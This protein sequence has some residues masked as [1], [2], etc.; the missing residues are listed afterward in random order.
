MIS[1]I[2][3]SIGRPSIINTL[4]SLLNQTNQDW[5]CLVGFDGIKEE[6]LKLNL[7]KDERIKYFYIDKKLGQIHNVHNHAGKVRNYLI[8]KVET[9]WIGFV[10]DDD[11]L[12][13]RYIEWFEKEKNNHNFDC[14][15]F[16]MKFSDKPLISPPYGC[17]SL[18]EGKVGISFVINK[19]F[20]NEN[21]IE[22][23]NY[24]SEDFIYLKE[25]EKNNGIIKFSDSIAYRVG[26]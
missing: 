7:P 23:I 19:N 2:I 1:F 14:L 11:S 10:D 13:K 24:V 8:N 6:D 12:E 20:I 26:F 21:K 3:P 15:I 25:I 9:E 22:F 18:I 5:K 4:S 16:K 17:F